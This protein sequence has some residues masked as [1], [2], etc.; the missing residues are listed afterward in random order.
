MAE[1][2]HFSMLQPPHVQCLAQSLQV[3]LYTAQLAE[4]AASTGE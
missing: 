3:S 2:N 4:V 1:G